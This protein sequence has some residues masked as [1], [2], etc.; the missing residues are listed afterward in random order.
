MEEEYFVV[1]KPVC[2]YC[3]NNVNFEWYT[4]DETEDGEI[5][6]F[7]CEVCGSSSPIASQENVIKWMN[8]I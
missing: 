3:N 5:G 2:A 4:L 7:N 1:L 6:C 8:E